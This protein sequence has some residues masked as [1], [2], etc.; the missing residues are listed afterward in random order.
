VK[1]GDRLFNGDC[2][3]VTK[4]LGEGDVDGAIE[5]LGPVADGGG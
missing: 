2:S 4:R 5:A 1:K 3:E